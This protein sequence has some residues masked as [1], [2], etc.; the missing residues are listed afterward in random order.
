MDKGT[1]QKRQA[2]AHLGYL[3]ANAG[4]FFFYQARVSKAKPLEDF[5]AIA[6]AA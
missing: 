4:R 5:K 3:K 1:E 2:E 6:N